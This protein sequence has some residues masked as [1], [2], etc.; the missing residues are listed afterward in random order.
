MR[1]F[2]PWFLIWLALLSVVP[3]A[4]T[5]RE[6]AAQSGC[7]QIT[8]CPATPPSV[9]LSTATTVSAPS[10]A[11]AVYFS[12]TDGLNLSS[13]R[14]WRNG[15]EISAWYDTAATGPAVAY[16]YP[17]ADWS[18]TLALVPGSNTLI[19]EICDVG[20]PSLCGRDTVVVTYEMGTI[21]EVPAAPVLTLAQPADRRAVDLEAATY[22][23][24]TVPYVTQDVPRS[25]V[26][27][28]SSEA[29]RPSAVIQVDAS[30]R[31]TQVPSRLSIQVVRND[32]SGTIVFPERFFAADTGAFRLVA[33]FDET[34]ATTPACSKRY[35]VHV[36]AYY[37]STSEVRS[38]SLSN[39]RVLVEDGRDN[40]VGSGWTIAG[41]ERLV[42]ESDGVVI[43]DGSG[44]LEY[45]AR[46]G[47]TG[48]GATETCTYTSP[49]G[50]LGTL[51]RTVVNPVDGSRYAR[52][53]PT[54]D[55]T[56]YDNAGL[57]VRTRSRFPGSTTRLHW[58][59]DSVGARL[60]SI[61][62]PMGKAIRL[63]YAPLSA[64]TYKPGSLRGIT[65]ADG[66]ITSVQ[67][68][69]ASGDLVR[70]DGP[71]GVADL[72]A[73]YSG[74]THRLTSYVERIGGATLG[75]DAWDHLS[76]LK[77]VAVPLE[78]GG[79]GADSVLMEPVLGRLLTG[80]SLMYAGGT[81]P[82][83]RL[84][85]AYAR[86]TATNGTQVRTWYHATGGPAMVEVKGPTGDTT[87]SRATYNSLGQLTSSQVTGQAAVTYEYDGL[88]GTLSSV[89][90]GGAGETRT[91]TPGPFGQT[92]YEHLN[93]VLMREAFFSGVGLAPDSVRSDTAN[94]VR[95]TYDAL[96]RL[97]RTRDARQMVDSVVYDGVTGNAISG[98][99]W[100]P[101][102]PVRTWSAAFDAAGRVVQM[103]D[104]LGRVRTTSYDLLNRVTKEK[105]LGTDSVRYVHL[106]SARISD[107]YDPLGNRYRTEYNAAGWPVAEIDPRGG[108]RSFG[109]DRRGQLVRLTDRRGRVITWEK[110]ALGRDVR[111]TADGA[112]TTYAYDPAKRWQAVENAESIDT[113]HVDAAGRPTRTV[114][115]R[116][117]VRYETTHQWVGT[118]PDGVTHR[119]FSGTTLLWSR[120]RGRGFD[121]ARRVQTEVDFG[122][123]WTQTTFDR[124]GAPRTTTLP[125]NVLTR[126]DTRSALGSLQQ[127]TYTGSAGVLSRGYDRDHSDRIWRTRWGTEGDEY[128]RVHTYDTRDRLTAWR[129]IRTWT[130]TI[131]E[132]WDP[133]G[134]CPGCFIPVEVTHVD[135]LQAATFGFDVLGNRTGAGEQ[136]A[137]GGGYRLTTAANGE[138]FTYDAEGQLTQ[139]SGGVMGLVTY[140]WNALGQLTQVTGPAGTTTYGYDGFGQR[141]RQTANG[142]VTRYVV[143]GGQVAVEVGAT[144]SLQA[145]YTYYPGTD[146][147]HGMWRGGQQYYYLQDAEG[148]VRGLVNAAGSLVETYT[149]T[150]DGQLLSGGGVVTNPY[151]W[152]GREWDAA[153]GL[154]YVRARYY[155][156]AVG[157]FVSEDPL[158]LAGGLNLYAFA[159]ADPVNYSDPSG[160]CPRNQS[161][162]VQELATVAIV[163]MPPEWRLG[164][165]SNFLQTDMRGG[166][167]LAALSSSDVPTV[168]ES[169]AKAEASSSP[170]PSWK[171]CMADDPGL[172]WA[173]AGFALAGLPNFKWPSEYQNGASVFG[174]IDR[175]ARRLGWPGANPDWGPEVRRVGKVGRRKVL[176]VYGTA[177]AVVVGLSA[178]YMLGASARCFVETH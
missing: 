174:S 123:G 29:A 96:G 164:W 5:P 150:P 151:R 80:G 40:R 132:S 16:E 126:T 14:L 12:D 32:G 166:R 114:S 99:T 112:V 81:A 88:Y 20:G 140:T 58:G 77:G 92:R 129:D 139:R 18:G 107:V 161:D 7:W 91:Y 160:L 95:F 84:A 61:V 157:R 36:R 97:V 131:W 148:N 89:Q 78:T 117:G 30:V 168:D 43:T 70:I 24:A 33:E 27:R 10:T 137:P 47:C 155:D 178:G 93:G 82:A 159:G 41:A 52:T 172:P 124:A 11:L 6:V 125:S 127:R 100:A 74:S 94:V 136:Y 46:T 154:Y 21:L 133:Y 115:V 76:L 143:E 162:C 101:S 85:D 118:L 110:D 145:A 103:T 79:T 122:G 169:T 39:V 158:G 165:T 156:P 53:W 83:R 25:V 64:G 35:T 67:V 102:E 134:D 57:V 144:G 116:A 15:V 86:T 163:A 3:L 48:S 177:S 98:R 22:A 141:V 171:A 152:K 72:T 62:D 4:L 19:A 68:P 105:A 138:T 90:Q 146:R 34:C 153:A 17:S 49:V 113:L 120:S 73:T 104:H 170:W 119:A 66:R 31:S 167:M 65:S 149:Y 8:L 13:R 45:F 173:A 175:R 75:Y 109:Y 71:D 42:A 2:R 60:D 1:T 63:S 108:T 28:Y 23:Y 26:L 121:A 130:E 9:L 50:S 135:T 51:R 69:S 59:A 55:S 128:S 56:F 142:V 37:G 147:P 38:S 111:M 44:G 87:V 106:D 54:G 176:G